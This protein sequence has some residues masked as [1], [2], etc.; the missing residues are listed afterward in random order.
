MKIQILAHGV[1]L[2]DNISEYL[3][4][5]I[6]TLSRFLKRLEAQ[7]EVLCQ[8]EISRESRHHRS[9]NVYY[10]EGTL[11]LPKK[12]LRAEY[13]EKN[14]LAAIDGVKDKLKAEILRYRE[15]YVL[16]RKKK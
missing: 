8:I 7:G 15:R 5:K 10:A 6:L 2:E 14:I 12:T 4:K 13:Y 3:E 16:R 1:S 9:G 11:A